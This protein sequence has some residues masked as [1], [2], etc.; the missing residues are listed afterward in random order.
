MRRHDGFFRR[1]FFLRS[2]L[3]LLLLVVLL[4]DFLTEMTSN[5]AVT[6]MMVPITISV[7]GAVGANPVFLAVATA[8]A[9]SM[10]FMLPVATPPN[11]LVYASGYVPLSRMIKSGFILDI[12][13]WILTVGV[14]LIFAQW[15]F[16]VIAL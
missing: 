1:R 6:S 10:A 4:T 8:V 5:T 2:S 9:S 15:L 11:A 16:G 3:L 13:G 14:L 7:A 12:I